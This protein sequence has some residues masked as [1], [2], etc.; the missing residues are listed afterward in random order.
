MKKALF[1]LMLFFGLSLRAQVFTCPYGP[2]FDSILSTD[3]IHVQ[4]R[5]ARSQYLH[6]YNSSNVSVQ[7]NNPLIIPV[8]VHVMHSNTEAVGQG[9]NITYAQIKSQ[10]DRMNADFANDT[11]YTQL[12]SGQYA[13]NVGIQFCLATEVM[14]PV[15]WTNTAEPGVMRHGVAPNNT[16]VLNQVLSSTYFNTVNAMLAL[17][18][19]TPNYF[20]FENYLNIWTVN[21]I[22]DSSGTA[23]YAGYSPKPLDPNPNN[24]LDGIVMDVHMFGDNTVNNNN[25]PI[26]NP[27]YNTGNICTHEAGHYLNLLHTFTGGCAGMTLGTCQT[28]GDLICDTPPNTN[29]S[30][31]CNVTNTCSE[32]YFTSGPANR[33]DM[34]E[35]YMTWHDDN[36]LNTFTQEQGLVMRNYLTVYRG[37]LVTPLNL[38][39]TG[40]ASP[41]GC[42]PAQ[43]L[44]SIIA[45]NTFCVNDTAD[46]TTPTG[47]GFLATSWTWQ[48]IGGTPSTSSLQNPSVV[49]STAGQQLIILTAFDANS[50][51]VTDSL[52][53]YVSPCAALASDQGH[54]YF[55]R[56]AGIDFSTG[57]AVHD[58][59]AY[60]NNT[61]D[62]VES[63]VS[64]SDSSGALLFYSDGEHV[65]DRNHNLAIS[66]MIGCVQTSKAQ[67]LAV[68]HPVH[69]NW[70][71]I[72]HGPEHEMVTNIGNQPIYYS[73]ISDSIGTMFP[74][75]LNDT[76][77]RH[78]GC[79]TI[80]EGIT[81]VP[82][83][84]GRDY[85]LITRGKGNTQWNSTLLI[86]LISAAGITDP[87]GTSPLPA[88]YQL[89]TSATAI[90]SC[91]KGSPDNSHIALTNNSNP[92]LTVLDFDNSTGVLSNERTAQPSTS[93][94]W[95]YGLSFS[96]D[97]RSVYFATIQDVFIWGVDLTQSTLTPVL[98]GTLPPSELPSA[99]QLGPDSS[100]YVPRRLTSYVSSFTNP[101]NVSSPGFNLQAVNVSTNYSQIRT[102]LGAPNM[103]DGIVPAAPPLNANVTFQNCSTIVYS[104][105]GCWGSGYIYTWNFGDNS[106]ISNTAT[107]THVYATSGQYTVSLVI[108]I[109]SYSYPPIVQQINVQLSSPPISG[110]NFACQNQLNNASYS[111]APNMQSY[112]W[113]VTGGGTI[114]G[115]ATQS[116]C[117]VAWSSNGTISCI[118]SNGLGCTFTTSLNVT[119]APSPVVDAGADTAYTCVN[120]PFPLGGNP[121]ASGG[122]AP[123]SY[124]WLPVGST[125]PSNSSNPL[126]IIS[127]PSTFT[128]IV[129]DA[130]GC[131]GSDM[132]FVGIDSS[133]T[134]PSIS[135]SSIPP[136]CDNATPIALNAYVSPSGGV[137]SGLG[138]TGSSFD[139][140]QALSPDTNTIFYLYTDPSN[141]CSS[142]DS[143]SVYVYDCCNTT[144]GIN[145]QNGQTSSMYGAQFSS[146]PTPVRINGTFYI[147]NT[148]FIS[149]YNGTNSVLCG[150]NATIVIKAGAR[151]VVQTGSVIRACENMWQGIII[152]PGGQLEVRTGSLIA[153]AKQAIVSQDGAKYTLDQAL[154]RDN[155]QNIIVEAHTGQGLHPGTIV[156]ST[157][158]GTILTLSPYVG[159]KTFSGMEVTGVDSLYVGIPT[160]SADENEFTGMDYGIITTGS[161]VFIRNNYFNNITS[162]QVFALP[163]CCAIGNCGPNVNCNA[164]PK[165]TAIWASGSSSIIGGSTTS[166]RNRF[167][168]CTRGIVAQDTIDVHIQN[169]RFQNITTSN[170][171]IQSQ[172]V[173]VRNC[174]LNTVT[175]TD[176]TIFS[177][178]NGIYFG[179]SKQTT[180]VI[181]YNDLDNMRGTSIQ[182]AQTT[183]CPVSIGVNTI[184]ATATSN[185]KYGIRVANAVVTNSTPYIQV[186]GNIT[187]MLEKHI[188][189]TNFPYI[190]VDSSNNVQF[191]DGVP[192]IAQYG[193]QVQNSHDAMVDGNTIVKNGGVPTD[194]N[195]RKRLYGI[196]MET[197]CYNT[198]VSNNG[199]FKVGTGVQYFNSNNYPSTISCN[200]FFNDMRGVLFTNTYIGDQGQPVSSSFPNGIAQDNQWNITGTQ[201]LVYKT[202]WA[203][204]SPTNNWYYRTNTTVYNPPSTQQRPMGYFGFYGPLTNAPSLCVQ[205]CGTCRTQASLAAL[206]NDEI[207]HDTTSDAAKFISDQ[208]VFEQLSKNEALMSQ[209]TPYDSTLI[210]FYNEKSG[211][212]VG[213]IN[214]AYSKAS[215]GDT[216]SAAAAKDAIV[217][218]GNPDMNHKLVLEVYLRS[219]GIG[220]Y[221]FTP[222]DSATLY[223]IAIQNVTSGG[224]AVYDARVML[225]LDID[226]QSGG[227]SARM[228][229]EGT[230]PNKSNG[231]L[232]PNPTVQSALYEITLLE[233]ESGYIVVTDV[234][235]RPVVQKPLNAGFNQ[236]ELDLSGMSSGVYLYK[237]IVL[238]ETRQTGKLILNK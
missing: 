134:A 87:T 153:D 10:I 80:N 126:S 12:P 61:I 146:V 161:N 128:V 93:N 72:F 9:L 43:L 168:T 110:P 133:L 151:L 23:H 117:N 234:F 127:A 53:V 101:N 52:Y 71:Y 95:F 205:P 19:P 160:T 197:N 89:A 120:S 155:Y 137:F 112:T 77:P 63:S 28:S 215:I 144:V 14:G 2:E 56:Y 64:I 158:A 169:N 37:S 68:P 5:L 185:G 125:S 98:V 123:Y 34:I 154:L 70:W 226:D 57:S 29:Q 50:N 11:V 222:E 99:F 113:S 229:N 192:A 216:A 148:F 58:N 189:I 66:G 103:I 164:A 65:W 227:S 152:E 142:Y 182:V 100:L 31:S 45:P 198:Q 78:V 232:Y 156:R 48:F 209:G 187:K 91:I 195:Y 157:V 39:L 224:T 150:S 193:I 147:N 122:T 115:S 81:A 67:I 180:G 109:G 135:F 186:H 92:G 60:L 228:A 38:S 1:L 212:N 47:N 213:L 40:V 138:V 116:T 159:I 62:A 210:Q 16:T 162:N 206:A 218:D 176:N 111:T 79:P 84:N 22:T 166:H 219:W 199:L 49:W 51:S 194:T 139:P 145:T 105:V 26:L 75:V 85:W 96:P 235:G 83:C 131:V 46:F 6:N 108:S 141:G 7:S 33:P 184:N 119:V 124:Q 82:H 32:S 106:P 44:A 74:I 238:D 214:E 211:E 55:G 104:T 207:P 167:V 20:P 237:T 42:V 121:T 59:A 129:T 175:I 132:I 18:H 200:N 76:L 208:S 35:N 165:G 230:E 140:S 204:N 25:F 191:I 54:W 27:N 4:S 190:V 233:G 17:T 15:Q 73:I 201:S 3:T 225:D 30:G 143:S 8:V 173:Q 188:W 107:G 136:M 220:V 13:V 181:E 170:A 88:T 183:E 94:N 217:P 97:S 36:C 21:Q 203:E 118:V 221:S 179:F 149:G 196:S 90:A 163:S 236:V 130:N 202:I 69:N 178:L 223:S 114:V 24:P 177:C 102:W 171:L 174:Y 86:Y 231:Y 172:C 41:A